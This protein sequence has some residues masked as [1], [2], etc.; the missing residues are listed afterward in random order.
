VSYTPKEADLLRK[1]LAADLAGEYAILQK[2]VAAVPEKKLGWKPTKTKSM[3]FGF[4][5]GHAGGAG[6]FFTTLVDGGKPAEPDYEFKTKK[7]LAKAID[8]WG[9]EFIEKLNGY[10]PKRL[11]QEI[12]F[13][14]QKHPVITLLRWHHVHL[15]HHRAQLSTYLR[16]M[17][18]KVPS[19]YGGSADDS[20]M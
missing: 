10:S 16:I 6:R 20:A 15:V 1:T 18:A 14:G 12:D 19:T 5:A 9:K 7:A 11:A 4:M 17:G 8:G 3:A 13:F 2:V